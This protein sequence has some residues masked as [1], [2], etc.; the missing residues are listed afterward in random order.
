M[1]SIL[2][3]LQQKLSAVGRSQSS[4]PRLA[5]QRRLTQP[6]LPLTRSRLIP[7]QELPPGAHVVSNSFPFSTTADAAWV[8]VDR[9]YVDTGGMAR[10]ELD[11]S[12]RVFLYRVGGTGGE[13]SEARTAPASRRRPPLHMLK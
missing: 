1:P 4:I 13:A 10:G 6:T 5:D 12:G 3:E 8:E 9:R 11:D 2:A 7:E